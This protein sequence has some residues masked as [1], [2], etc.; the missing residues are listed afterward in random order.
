[1]TAPQSFRVDVPDTTLDAI[2]DRVRAYPWHEMPANG[3]WAYGANLDYMKELCAYW[4]DGFD[5]R[6]AEAGLNRFPQFIAPITVEGETVPIHFIHEKGSGTD[7]RPLII[8]HGWPGSIFEFMAVIEPLAHPERFGG[9]ADDGFDVVVPSLIGYGFSGKPQNPMG[10]RRIAAYFAKLMGETLGYKDYLAQGGDWGSAISSH[11]GLDDPNCAAVH[12]NMQGWSSPGAVP[13]TPDEIKAAEAMQAV[14]QAELAYFQLQA[15]KPQSLSYAMMDSPVG[16]AAWLVEKFNTWSH[17]DGDNI[18]SAYTKDQLLT[19]IMIYLVTRTFNT[20]TWTY[21]GVFEDGYGAPY[22]AG[23]RLTKPVAIANFPN[24]IFQWAPRSQVEK[25]FHVARWTDMPRG[26]HFAALEAPDLFV[27]DV[28]AFGR[29][30]RALSS[31][32]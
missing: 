21:R 11:L 22:P 30:L 27:E 7:P 19:N 10:P 12:L 24:D 20:A 17:T 15:T 14:R 18:E 3:G 28:R 6:A 4:L 31:V 16:V 26:G 1:M 2:A 13:E 9:D 8:S 32:S 25:S 23:H 5:W 29:D